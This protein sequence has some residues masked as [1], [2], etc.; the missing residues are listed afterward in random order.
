MGVCANI[1][2]S[3]FPWQSVP[4]P[5]AYFPFNNYSANSWPVPDNWFWNSTNLTA[6]GWAS[7]DTFG[8]VVS[9][10]VS[11]LLAGSLSHA[12]P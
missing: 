3:F 9:C 4:M 11:T 8:S 1:E 5:A 6:T 12:V 7:D 2:G 10:Q